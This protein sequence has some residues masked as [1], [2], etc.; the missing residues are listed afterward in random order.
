MPARPFG[1][2]GPPVPIVGQGTW[3]F[4]ARGTALEE[5]KRALREGV[6]LGMVH[7]DTAEMYGDGASEK[8]IA[9]ALAG[10][11]RERLFI[12]SK[13]LPSNASFAQTIRSCEASLRRLRTSYLDCYLLHWRGAYPLEQTMAALEQLA[14][15]GKIRA[16][17]VSNFDV[18]DLEEAQGYLRVHRIACNQVLYHLRERGIERRIHPFCADRG[19]AV[20]AYSPFG[21]GDFPGTQTRAGK[22][23]A[24]IAHRYQATPRQVAL[25]FLLRLEGTFAI[26]KAA[27]TPHVV[28][29]S[30][31]GSLRLEAGDVAAIDA[32]FPR[33]A[34]DGPL[35]ML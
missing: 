31:A 27:R 29:N 6:E 24:E 32:A 4:P 21:S 34:R 35:A 13:V 30:G 11:D 20:V 5:A 28:E 8:I 18:E 22:V 10:I 15:D 33:P 17:G 23:L 7:I 19:I 26:P 14:S 9:D 16:L 25:A 12:V 2:G 3:N 1:P